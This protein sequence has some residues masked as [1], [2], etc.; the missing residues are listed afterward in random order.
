MEEVEDFRIRRFEFGRDFGETVKLKREVESEVSSVVSKLEGEEHKE[1]GPVALKEITEADLELARR[2]GEDRG[3]ILGLEEGKAKY[4][5]EGYEAGELSGREKVE[6]EGQALLYQVGEKISVEIQDF[7]EE[8]RSC[9]SEMRG[10]CIHV[11]VAVLK[12]IVP[13][14]EERYGHEELEAQLQSVL[15]QLMEEDEI[16]VVV[17][18]CH[19]GGEERI[20]GLFR[21][22]GLE[23]RVKFIFEEGMGVSDVRVAW[24]G[25]S[26]ERNIEK[27]W[28]SVD[29]LIP[30]GGGLEGA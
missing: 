18:S 4:Y 26:L 24:H 8:R 23:D 27:I 14:Y 20:R 13:L 11:A 2:E 16:R 17:S 19:R 15:V 9:F 5:R 30:S 6:S 3:R 1:E 12:K 7:L 25:G 28:R 10:E 21:D 29:E 22:S